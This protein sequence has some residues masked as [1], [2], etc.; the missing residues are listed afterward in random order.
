MVLNV[1]V[2]YF[3]LIVVFLG[4]YFCFGEILNVKLLGMLFFR[5]FES[6]EVKDLCGFWNF[7]VDMF[8]N[9]MVGFE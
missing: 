3:V 9:R 5:E 1:M 6:C 7:W 2:F 4:S 8:V